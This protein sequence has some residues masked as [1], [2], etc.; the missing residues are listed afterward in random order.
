VRRR[1]PTLNS[2]DTRLCAR[3][4]GVRLE[5]RREASEKREREE[6]KSESARG[7]EKGRG[8]VGYATLDMHQCW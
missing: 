6:S 8:E 3:L 2:A 5:R 7:I 1:P 4:R